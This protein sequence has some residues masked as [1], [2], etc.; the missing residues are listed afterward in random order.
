MRLTK[1]QRTALEHLAAHA[2]PWPIYASGSGPTLMLRPDR[3]WLMIP[4]AQIDRLVSEG[5]LSPV[6][7][8]RGETVQWLIT[9]AGRTA[10]TPPPDQAGP[11]P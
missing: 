1:V 2:E 4:Q 8:S 9:D 6:T 10:V 3:A 11:T 7:S 5:L